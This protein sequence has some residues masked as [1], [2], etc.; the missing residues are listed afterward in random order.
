MA[1]ALDS[2][3]PGLTQAQTR[4]LA[5]CGGLR[6]GTFRKEDVI[7]LAGTRVREVGIVRTG[8]VRVEA[9]DAWGSRSLLS[10]VGP[11]QTFAET[12]ALCGEVTLVSAVAAETS[13]IVFL[14]LPRLLDDSNRSRSWYPIILQ[15][16]MRLCA[17]KNLVLSE[18]IFCTTPKTV[19]GRLLTYLSAESARCG[20]PVF[21]IPLD[22][23]QLA[24]YLNLNR[25]A[26]SKELSRMRDEGLLRCH[27][28]HF[29][30]LRPAQS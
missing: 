23:Q 8:S 2:V 28:N 22:R 10:R 17:R 15:G 5:D 30:L 4:E 12:Y 18:R 25:S 21:E 9:C 19:R 27:K 1:S 13:E 16:M 26:V 20:S 3:F 11:G 14:H 7:F 24:D 6:V 29:E